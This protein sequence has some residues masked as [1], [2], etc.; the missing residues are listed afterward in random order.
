MVRRYSILKT[1]EVNGVAMVIEEI[2]AVGEA[3]AK[4]DIMRR[5]GNQTNRTGMEE[6]AVVGEAV[7]QIIPTS[8]ATIHETDEWD[9]NKETEGIIKIGES[10]TAIP[11]AISENS[12]TIDNEDEPRQSKMRSLQDLYDS[13]NEVRQGKTGIF[14]SQEAYAKEILKKY[15]MESCNPVSIPM[16]PRAK[17][18]KFDGGE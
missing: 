5:R 7:G 6:D 8:S 10:S 11:T 13:T 3:A 1:F 14:V 12:E 17:L 9:W 16:E 15:K 4:K 2:V 18:S